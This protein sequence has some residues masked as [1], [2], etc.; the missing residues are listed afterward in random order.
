MEKQSY[1]KIFKIL[2][3][4]L[5]IVSVG[6]LVWGF[7]RG[8]EVKDGAAVNVLLY[9]A[10]AMLGL[11][12]AAVVLV[13]LYISIRTNP[14]SLVKLGIGVVAALVLCGIAYLLASGAPAV[15]FTG[16]VPP[17][18]SELKL[19]DTVLNLA[20]ILGAG[21]ILSIIAAEVWGAIRSKKA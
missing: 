1:A 2:S 13:G 3:W 21:A 14:K 4:V 15:G 17:T 16:S 5:M 12:I 11:A 7:L 9:W 6:L 20:Y 18:D 8:F 19:T 10:Y